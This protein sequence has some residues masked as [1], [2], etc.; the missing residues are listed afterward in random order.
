M[1]PDP[2]APKRNRRR[3]AVLLAAVMMAILGLWSLGLG[4]PIVMVF[5]F[6]AF[7]AV[8]F[9]HL[10]SGRAW[11]RRARAAANIPSHW[12][13]RLAELVAYYRELGPT[14]RE[15]FRTMVAV[16]LAEVPVC[17]AGC[18]I[19]EDDRLLVAAG[20]VIPIFGFPAF[21]YRSVREVLIR[22]RDFDPGFG[23]TPDPLLPAQA[24]AGGMT[25][26][27]GVFDAVVV[28][29]RERLRRGFSVADDGRNVAIHEFAHQVDKDYVEEV[30]VSSS[31][32]ER[33]DAWLEAARRELRG[34]H[35]NRD[36][37]LRDYGYSNEHEFFAVASE[38]F[39]ERPDAMQRRRPELYKLLA[40]LYRQ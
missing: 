5:A 27:G 4:W 40:Q 17:G 35:S 39:F 36:R 20:A 18:S 30:A 26:H 28:L 23:A 6:C 33:G 16:F 38:Y 19:D 9:R 10:R 3:T 31:E 22:P 13:A 11:R 25:G 8:L 15:R 34:A 2:Q 37:L 14:E 24:A 29:V 32:D 21:E 12:D 7:G 1:L